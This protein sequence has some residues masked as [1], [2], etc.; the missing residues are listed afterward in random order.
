MIIDLKY[1]S[2]YGDLKNLVTNINLSTFIIF[3]NVHS[4]I[5]SGS[6][7]TSILYFL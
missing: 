2:H 3:L 7:T 5:N 4:I 1:N 6:N